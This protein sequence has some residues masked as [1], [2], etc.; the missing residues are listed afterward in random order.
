MPRRKKEVTEVAV[1][2]V[3]RVEW[4]LTIYYTKLGKVWNDPS[5]DERAV[6][7]ITKPSDAAAQLASVEIMRGGLTFIENDYVVKIPPHKILQVV[8]GKVTYAQS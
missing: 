6:R 4:A 3:E 8:I 7:I 5:G 2:T 1:S